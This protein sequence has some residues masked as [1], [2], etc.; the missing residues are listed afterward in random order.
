MG[1]FGPMRIVT[2]ADGSKWEI[3]VYRFRLPSWRPVD[4]DSSQPRLVKDSELPCS[5]PS[6]PSCR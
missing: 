1:W 3:Y 6:T 5:P 4:Y 2:A